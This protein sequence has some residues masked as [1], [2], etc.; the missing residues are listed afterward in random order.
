[1]E[2]NP[3]KQIGTSIETMLKTGRLATQTGLDLQQV[4]TCCT[5]FSS[6]TSEWF[7]NSECG[8]LLYF[9]I[10]PLCDSLFL[11]PLFCP[12][13]VSACLNSC[14]LVVPLVGWNLKH[15]FTL[16]RSFIISCT[17]I[18][19]IKYNF[20]LYKTFNPFCVCNL[21][22]YYYFFFKRMLRD[23]IILGNSLLKF[24]QLYS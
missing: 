24:C 21:F 16:N 12:P 23:L 11:A 1:M 5:Y 18:V 15:N 8:L 9:W 13:A 14:N 4:L 6:T 3:S 2:K 7:W 19:S 17:K 10:F 20:V 22:I